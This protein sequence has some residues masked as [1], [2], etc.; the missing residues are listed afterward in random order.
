MPIGIVLLALF[1]FSSA[2]RVQR[3]EKNKV[4]ENQVEYHNAN[5]HG[6]EKVNAS[7]FHKDKYLTEQTNCVTRCDCWMAGA[8]SH[9]SIL[10][11]FQGSEFYKLVNAAYGAAVVAFRCWYQKPMRLRQISHCIT[12]SSA[13]DTD[14]SISPQAW[15]NVFGLRRAYDP[16]SSWISVITSINARAAGAV[17]PSV[18]TEAA[19]VL[20]NTVGSGQ[21]SDDGC[22]DIEC[23]SDDRRSRRFA[24]H[25]GGGAGVPSISAGGVVETGVCYSIVWEDC[26]LGL[27]TCMTKD[28]A[29]FKCTCVSG[30]KK[31][32]TYSGQADPSCNSGSSSP[33]WS[34]GSDGVSSPDILGTYMNEQANSYIF[35][36]FACAT[37]SSGPWTS[38]N[39]GIKFAKYFGA[40]PC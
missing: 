29:Y 3:E 21:W 7:A 27:S 10:D 18:N 12:V 2:L 32:C 11:C 40:T 8:G 20:F 36:S 39:S 6:S 25:G 13:A 22:L 38:G 28:W 19:I 30:N 34:G 33:P 4:E 17:A 37:P 1:P 24:I 31:V 5:V 23:C 16:W 14:Y 15:A 9:Y 35:D 26:L